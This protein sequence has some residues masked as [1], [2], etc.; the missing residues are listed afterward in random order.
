MT[1]LVLPSHL[2]VPFAESGFTY[3]WRRTGDPHDLWQQEYLVR[4]T[5]TGTE[6]VIKLTDRFV[7]FVVA[8]HAAITATL[9]ERLIEDGLAMAPV[10]N[11]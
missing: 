6:F 9:L 7:T 4:D 11:G 5:P 2:Q 3:A 1:M 8:D 10:Q